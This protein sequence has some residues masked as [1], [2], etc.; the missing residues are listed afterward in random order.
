M[1]AKRMGFAVLVAVTIL[2]MVPLANAQGLS[3]FGPNT[4]ATFGPGSGCDTCGQGF[5]MGLGVRKYVDGF[6]SFQ[7]PGRDFAIANSPGKAR[8][9]WPLD[10]W[11]GVIRLGYDRGPVGVV[12]D[13]MA[14]CGS[15]SGT[16]AQQT[17]WDVDDGTVALFGR[18]RVAPRANVFDLGFTYALPIPAKSCEE[19]SFGLAA[20]VGFRQQTYRYTLKD[21]NDNI[22]GSTINN[23][24]D[25]VEFGQYYTHY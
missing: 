11:F 17:Y 22:P 16:K 13:Y 3:F 8:F 12:V 10:Q 7:F 25:D 19:P 21:S 2:A 18:G 9:E 24:G 20:I 14:T 5:W 1:V 23:R 15:G 4:G 6:T